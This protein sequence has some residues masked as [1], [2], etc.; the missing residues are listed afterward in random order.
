MLAGS[1]CAVTRRAVSASKPIRQVLIE[2]TQ[3]TTQEE[4]PAAPTADGRFSHTKQSQ[5]QGFLGASLNLPGIIN[6]HK[7]QLRAGGHPNKALQAD[8]NELGEENFAFE[9]VDELTPRAGDLVDY[10]AELA[11][12]EKLWLEKLHPLAKRL[13]RAETKQIRG[14]FSE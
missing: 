7:S 12:L 8:W 9:I 3:E 14:C 13:Q 11:F 6:R 5:R 10:R 1:I 4:L 2:R